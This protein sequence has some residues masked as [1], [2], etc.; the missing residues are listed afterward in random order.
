MTDS[1]T[2]RAEVLNEA[3]VHIHGDRNTQYGPPTVNFDRIAGFWSTY[4]TGILGRE[5]VIEPY[6]VADMNILQKVARNIE[7]PK[8]DNYVDTAGYAACGWE[9]VKTVT[10]PDPVAAIDL[11]EALEDPGPHHG[12]FIGSELTGRPEVFIPA[13]SR[14]YSAITRSAAEAQKRADAENADAD[15]RDCVDNGLC[16]CDSCWPGR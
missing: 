11:A 9:T 12:L 2:P 15:D 4:L 14:S 13:G 3:N 6:Q 8:R 16:R 7:Q 1:E 5:I 10:H